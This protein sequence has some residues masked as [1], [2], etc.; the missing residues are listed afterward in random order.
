M[1]E[2]RWIS[3]TRTTNVE[4]VYMPWRLHTDRVNDRS[5]PFRTSAG[6]AVT[7]YDNSLRPG[8]PFYWHGLTL[9]PAWTGNYIHY[10]TVAPLKFGTGFSNFIPHFTE[11]VITCPCRDLIHVR[12]W[13][14]CSASSHH[15]NQYWFIIYWNLR[16]K[17]QLVWIIKTQRFHYENIFEDFVCKMSAFFFETRC[18]QALF[19]YWLHWQA[20]THL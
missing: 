1:M 12:K 2:L 20:N 10:L 6:I 14:P 16:N 4:S 3:R 15:L 18:A 9:I 11:H 19:I 8:N 13:D 7:I 5:D 17:I